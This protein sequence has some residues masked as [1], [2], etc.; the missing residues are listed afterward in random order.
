MVDIRR[1]QPGDLPA[2][3]DIYNHYVRETAI[4]FD[5]EPR[6][7]EQRRAWLDGFAATGRHQCFVAV[8]DGRPIGWASSGRF[9]ERAAYDTTVETSVYLAPGE[10]GQGL[11]QRLYQTLFDALA[12]EDIH[13]AYGG[14][15]QPNDASDR[16]H[17]RMGFVRAGVLDAVGRKFGRFWDV[18]VWLRPFNGAAGGT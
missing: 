17:A 4:T 14:V 16:L 15:T 10:T 5:L 7:L 11:G 13:R 6:T 3:L 1:I 12:S 9:R 2:L 18:A 8:K